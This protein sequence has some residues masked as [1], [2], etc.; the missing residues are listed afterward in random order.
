MESQLQTLLFFVTDKHVVMD[1]YGKRLLYK[2]NRTWSDFINNIQNFTNYVYCD[3][4]TNT[5]KLIK[6]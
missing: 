3:V 2:L 4:I 1:L 6:F 5:N